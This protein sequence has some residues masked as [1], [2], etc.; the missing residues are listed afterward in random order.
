MS[1]FVRLALAGLLAILIAAGATYLLVA[2]GGTLPGQAADHI[3]RFLAQLSER[4]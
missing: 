2:A 4:L 1:K 3:A